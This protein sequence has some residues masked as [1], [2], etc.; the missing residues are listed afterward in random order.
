M[1]RQGIWLRFALAWSI[2][3]TVTLGADTPDETVSPTV[4]CLIDLSVWNVKQPQLQNE[5]PSTLPTMIFHLC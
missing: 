1:L 3:V 5:H 2:V 4:R